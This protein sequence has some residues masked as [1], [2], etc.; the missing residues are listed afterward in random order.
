TRLL[1]GRVSDTPAKRRGAVEPAPARAGH[2]FN[3]YRQTE[4]ER[5]DALQERALVKCDTLPE[6]PAR[7]KCKTEVVARFAP[8]YDSVTNAVLADKDYLREIAQADKAIDNFT[9]TR[10]GWFWEIAGGYS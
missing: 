2:T 7:D 6:G 5:L 4:V 10:E 9:L 8:Q 3:R 1:A